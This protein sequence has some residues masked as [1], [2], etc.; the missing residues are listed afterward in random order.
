[1]KQKNAMDT[2]IYNGFR[3]L[4]FWPGQVCYE[5]RTSTTLTL[6][7]VILEGVWATSTHYEPWG[8]SILEGL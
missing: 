8:N 3:V 2:G 1:M 4:A 5:T 6:Q 7:G